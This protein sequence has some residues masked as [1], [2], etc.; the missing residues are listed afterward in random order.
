MMRTQVFRLC[1]QVAAGPRE[2]CDQSMARMRAPSSPPP[3]RKP[4]ETLSGNGES[5]AVIAES[6]RDWRPKQCGCPLLLC[7]R[8][9]RMPPVA[10]RAERLRERRELAAVGVVGR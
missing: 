7:Q 8:M 2:V 9:L 3:A 1:G 10:E 4:A 6:N 5:S